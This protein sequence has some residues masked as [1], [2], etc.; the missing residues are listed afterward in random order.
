MVMRLPESIEEVSLAN[1]RAA[2][3]Q[4]VR[5]AEPELTVDEG[6]P[7][8]HIIDILSVREMLLREYFNV[9]VRRNLVRYASGQDLDEI[10][11]LL[12]TPRNTQEADEPYRNRIIVAYARSS[13]VAEQSFLA[14]A[15]QAVTSVFD[16][17]YVVSDIK[18]T[19]V[20]VLSSENSGGVPGMPSDDT[21]QAVLN[22]L[23]NPARHLITDTLTCP[24]PT[25]TEF[26]V[27]AALTIEAGATSATVIQA[28]TT[29]LQAY[30]ATAQRLGREWYR[31]E[32]AAVIQAV[33]GVRGVSMTGSTTDRTTV[34]NNQAYY[35]GTPTITVP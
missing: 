34:P 29:A 25:L 30:N 14:N 10:G 12:D 1:I 35:I 23:N 33:P 18:A 7:V 31:S 17:N 11:L 19:A 22:Y 15:Q 2:I 5:T 20:Y 27:V 32:V 3:L 4:A 9:R 6:S 26:N 13:P 16:A 24:A 8:Y 28:A 21:R